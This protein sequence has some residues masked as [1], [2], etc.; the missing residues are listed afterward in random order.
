MIDSP[1][2][3]KRATN[4]TLNAKVLD[5]ARELGINISQTVDDLLAREVRR[6]TVQKWAEDN[7]ATVDAYNRRIADHGLFNDDLRKMR[8]QV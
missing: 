5:A 6:R 3:Q 8:G 2:S 1:H 4:L 7:A